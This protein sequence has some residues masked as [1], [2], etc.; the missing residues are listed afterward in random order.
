MHL[1][2]LEKTYSQQENGPPCDLI[3]TPAI[4][5]LC[6]LAKFNYR[7]GFTTRLDPRTANFRG[8]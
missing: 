7:A 6:G 1:Q 2:I 4:A 5:L 8:R 3:H